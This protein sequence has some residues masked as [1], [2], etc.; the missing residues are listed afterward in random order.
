MVLQTSMLGTDE[1]V[2]ERIRRYRDSGIDTLRLDAIGT[3]ATSRL[4][5][6]GHA[7][8]LVREECGG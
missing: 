7:I 5:T 6:L 1:M 2:R 8:E 3:D 4:D